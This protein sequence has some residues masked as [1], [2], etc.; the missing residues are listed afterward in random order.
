MLCG[1]AIHM[2][3]AV[4]PAA[5]AQRAMCANG[6]I[7]AS[8]ECLGGIDRS[9]QLPQFASPMMDTGTARN[10]PGTQQLQQGPQGTSPVIVVPQ[11]KPDAP[12]AVDIPLQQSPLP[13]E[14]PLEFQTLVE[15]STGKR[16]SVYGRDLFANAPSTFAPLEGS[17]VTADY[18]IGPGDEFHVRLWGQVD[19]DLRVEVDRSGMIFIPRVGQVGVSGVRFQDLSG[20]LRAAVGRVFRNFDLSV[21]MGR[22]RSIQIFVTGYARRPG[23]YTVSSLSSLA[24]AVFAAGGPSLRGSMRRIELKRSDHVIAELDLYQLLLHGSKAND[25]R[26]MPGDVVSIPPVGPLIAVTGSVTQPSIYELRGRTSFMDAIEIAGGL[27]NTA[28]VGTLRVERVFDGRARAVDQVSLDGDAKTKLAKD[29]DIIAVLSVLPRYENTVT[30]RGNV[31][32]PGR[33]PWREGLRVRDLVP[34]RDAL[35]AREYWMKRNELV[36]ALPAPRGSSRNDTSAKAAGA[37]DAPDAAGSAH[38]RNGELESTTSR[39]DGDPISANAGDFRRNQERL[40][41]EIKRSANEINWDYAVIERL[42][43]QDLSTTLIP[44]DL[45]QAVLEGD[46]RHNV[47]LRPGDVVTVFSKEDIQVSSDKQ[48]V[49]VRLEGEFARPGLYQAQPGETMRQ[50]VVRVGGLSQNAYLYGASFIRESAREAQQ[51]QLSEYV[52]RFERDVEASLSSQLQRNVSGDDQQAARAQADAQRKLVERLRQIRATG[53]IVLELK[54]DAHKV[55]DL[56]DIPL[57]DGDRLQVPRRP[58]VVSVIGA[59]YGRNIQIYRPDKTTR[60]YLEHAGGATTTADEGSIYLLHADGSVR[61]RRQ[62]GWGGG[63]LSSRLNPGDAIVVPDQLDRFNFS[64]E[65]KDWAQIFYQL[66]LGAAGLASI[67]NF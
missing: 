62:D 11:T 31:A 27:S 64:R 45:G 14:E 22:L 57:E 49:Y 61:N 12:R 56:P 10:P 3:V 38:A 17:P 53:R 41:V 52:D 5:Y 67:R 4:S 58:S 46:P 66:A 1:I 34:E 47:L 48:S 37:R 43:P 35:V 50:L 26:L 6:E 60:E 23:V 54:P 9:G 2:T 33:Y 7:G 32:D 16:L 51:V 19:A 13:D 8:G 20:H 59:V 55:A 25:A 39:G 30:L 44:F 40:R 29:G 15:Q 63:V 24:N 28:R 18:L 21:S 65:I 42:N 36:Q